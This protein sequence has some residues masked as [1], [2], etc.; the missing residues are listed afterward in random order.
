MSL[1]KIKVYKGTTNPREVFSDQ[2]VGQKIIIVK[3]VGDATGNKKKTKNFPLAFVF[4]HIWHIII[5][6]ICHI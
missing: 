4:A 2:R 6:Q 5:G 1:A 3:I